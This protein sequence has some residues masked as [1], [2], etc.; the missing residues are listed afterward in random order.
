MF[1]LFIDKIRIS[2]IYQAQKWPLR[3][4]AAAGFYSLIAWYCGKQIDQANSLSRTKSKVGLFALCPERFRGDLEALES[5]PDFAIIRCPT[6]LAYLL[7]ALYMQNKKDP[8]GNYHKSDYFLENRT[9]DFEKQKEKLTIFYSRLLPHLFKRYQIVAVLAPNFTMP[10]FDLIGVTAKG[11]GY[12]YVVLHREGLVT[13]PELIETNRRWIN[14][15]GRFPGSFV[16]VHNEI[17]K[18]TLI[19]SGYVSNKE[20]AA[21]GCIRMDDLIERI[22]DS[23]KAAQ[24]E[25]EQKKLV[26]FSFTPGSGFVG[27]SGAIHMKHF[28]EDRSTGLWR[29]F[30]AVHRVVGE[31]ARDHPNIEVVVKTKWAEKWH[32]EIE[33]IW[34]DAGIDFASMRNLHLT[35]SGDAHDLIFESTA[36]SS[37]G[38]TTMI[39][40]AIVGRPVIFPYFEEANYEE[41]QSYIFFR[42]HQDLFDIASSAEQY[43]DLLLERLYNNWNIAPGL[44]ERRREVFDQYVSSIK[45]GALKRYVSEIHRLTSIEQINN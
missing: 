38:S 28:S 40:A 2:L 21:L 43:R 30:S 22:E 15:A 16:I 44:L 35:S 1:D 11:L 33:N 27:I 34:R 19:E 23:K 24:Q 9:N 8:D 14:T 29:L 12:P 45:G 13:A 3:L 32:G 6:S 17:L 42:D 20:I 10:Q 25:S 18:T 7:N 39:E 37:Y 5:M 31:I 41:Y 26:L 36:I 4:L